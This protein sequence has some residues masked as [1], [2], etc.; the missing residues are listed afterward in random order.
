MEPAPPQVRRVLVVDDEDT[1]R[2][3]LVRTLSINGFETRDA[4]DGM[5]AWALALS[6]RFDLLVTDLRMPGLDGMELA[7]RVTQAHPSTKVLVVSAYP[8]IGMPPY[9]FMHK[10]FSME[11]F[12]V[13][14]GRLFAPNDV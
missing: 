6:Q 11:E 2:R 3:S 10:P 12:L 9:P 4:G 1:I 13:S 8:P 7:A 14:V 5:T